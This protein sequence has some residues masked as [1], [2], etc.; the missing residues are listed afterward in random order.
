MRSHLPGGAVPWIAGLLAVVMLTSGG[1]LLYE[2][3]AEPEQ[4]SPAAAGSGRG[5]S[6]GEPSPGAPPVGLLPPEDLEGRIAPAASGSRPLPDAAAGLGPLSVEQA[7]RAGPVPEQDVLRAVSGLQTLGM[8]DGFA[9]RFDTD[10]YTMTVVVYRF[11]APDGAASLVELATGDTV[12]ASRSGVPG[13]ILLP[14]TPGST[15]VGG[16]F[17]Y[18]SNAY[19]ITLLG[20]SGAVDL[21]D[22]DAALRRQYEHVVLT[23]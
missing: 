12:V 1:F 4:P 9:R 6:T 21:T 18:G 19:E 22:V 7:V 5:D 16:L 10:R 13:A 11:F 23:G 8:Q 17:S 2:R 20:K 14:P 3:A 15:D